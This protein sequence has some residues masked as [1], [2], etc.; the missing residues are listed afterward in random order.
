M[1]RL[2]AVLKLLEE[3]EKLF[4]ESGAKGVN[5]EAQRFMHHSNQAWLAVWDLVKDVVE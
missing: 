1:D 5:L 4:K 3:A 2:K